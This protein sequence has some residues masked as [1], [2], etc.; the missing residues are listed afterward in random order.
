[1]LL[2]NDGVNKVLDIPADRLYRKMKRRVCLPGGQASRAIL[3]G[4]PKSRTIEHDNQH[5]YEKVLDI[6]AKRLYSRIEE[7][8]CHGI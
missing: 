8:A 5:G 3:A 2:C 1:M 4:S 6:P 7:K